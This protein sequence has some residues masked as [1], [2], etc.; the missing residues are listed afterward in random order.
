MK[1]IISG[2]PGS[3]KSTVAKLLAKK[4]KVPH[5]SMGDL[6]R[7]VAAEKGVTI[8]ELM[9]LEETDPTIDRKIDAEQVKLGKEQKDFVLDSRLGAYF[10]PDAEVRVFLD[11]D[12]DVL[13]TRVL[14]AGR[15]DEYH[16]DMGDAKRQMIEREQSN[17]KRYRELYSIDYRAKRWFNCFIDT[18][19]KTP[20]EVADE[21]VA[22]V[23]RKQKAFIPRE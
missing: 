16:K 17:D 10:L 8:L 9:K 15:K 12:A 13:A 5:Y 20:E 14:L 4:L 3:G 2:M 7:R 11:G 22:F 18:T 23:K 21:I 19:S 6:Q 1:I